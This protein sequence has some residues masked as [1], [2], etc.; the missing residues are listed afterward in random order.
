VHTSS[1][2][3]AWSTGRT[4]GIFRTALLDEPDV[5]LFHHPT[6]TAGFALNAHAG[7]VG[8]GNVAGE[9]RARADLWQGI[10]ATASSVYP[11]QRLVGYESGDDLDAALAA[12]FETL[13]PLRV[14]IR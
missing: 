2:L 14:W 5:R 11:G 12:G 1:D 8:V 10:V 7:V 6:L 4:P 3:D 9:P 13:G